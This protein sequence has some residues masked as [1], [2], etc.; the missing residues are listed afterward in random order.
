MSRVMPRTSG[1]GVPAVLLA[2][3]FRV[4]ACGVIDTPHLCTVYSVNDQSLDWSCAI[5]ARFFQ[6]ATQPVHLTWDVF[7]RHHFALRCAQP[8]GCWCHGVNH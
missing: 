7:F 5:V 3:A 2:V 4:V 6:V 1:R 8:L